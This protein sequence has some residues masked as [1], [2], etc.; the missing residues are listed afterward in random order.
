MPLFSDVDVC[1]LPVVMRITLIKKENYAKYDMSVP[2]TAPVITISHG[3]NF[4]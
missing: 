2:P 4:Q 1:I 3:G